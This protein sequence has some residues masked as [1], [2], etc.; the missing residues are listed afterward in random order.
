M[1]GIAI[2]SVSGYPGSGA[3]PSWTP[4]SATALFWIDADKAFS[5]GRLFQD[6]GKTSLVTTA[7]QAV[8]AWVQEG[9][10][11]PDLLQS[12]AL[13]KGYFTSLSSGALGV[14]FDGV[15]DRLASA[16]T[17]SAGAKT[18]AFRFQYATALGVTELDTPLSL[19]D[20][21]G[22]VRIF[23]AG[24]SHA[25]YPRLSWAFDLT[26]ASAL[27]MGSNDLTLNTSE[28][29]VIIAYNGGTRTD[30]AS[31][32]VWVDGVEGTVTTRGSTTAS[33]TT[34][35]GAGSAGAAPAAIKYA[36]IALLQGDQSAI[37]SSILTWL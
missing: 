22:Q 35:I 37:V 34:S 30:P 20:A 36:R 11:T 25:T 4:A 6:S 24:A 18:L 1:R 14:G 5:G 31:Y 7:L 28:H 2:L 3:A 29:T 27:F 26:G 8:G 13:T 33:G 32:R 15:D 19:G 9:A 17:F 10:I 21:T 16:Q 12:G 23:L